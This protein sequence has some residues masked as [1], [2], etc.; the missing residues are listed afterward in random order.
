MK[1]DILTLLK[2]LQLSLENGKS[3]T[4]ALNLLQ[5]IAKSKD[6]R[7]AYEKITRSIQEGASFS[8]AL[9]KYVSPSSDI[10]QFVAMAEKRG[11]ICKNSKI[12]G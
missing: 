10:I 8:K 1:P 9:E 7:V 3:L 5:S 4:N 12:C 11:I 2:T 6:E